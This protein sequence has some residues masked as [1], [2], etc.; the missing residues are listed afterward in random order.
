[1]PG[2]INNILILIHHIAMT[3]VAIFIIRMAGTRGQTMAGAAGGLP[4]SDIIPYHFFV[5]TQLKVAVTV[6]IGTGSAGRIPHWCH[7][8][9]IGSRCTPFNVDNSIAVSGI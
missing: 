8:A 9:V 7:F 5:L 3:E 1:M 4:G 6:S 2:F